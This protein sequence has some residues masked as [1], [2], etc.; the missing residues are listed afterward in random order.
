MRVIASRDERTSSGESREVVAEMIEGD[1]DSVLGTTEPRFSEM[2]ELA[3]DRT[4]M[5]LFKFSEL[6]DIDTTDAVGHG[7]ARVGL[8]TKARAFSDALFAFHS[9]CHTSHF[10]SSIWVSPYTRKRLTGQ[11]YSLP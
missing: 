6:A 10:H 11:K 5:A 3:L 1:N 9:A 4:D 8:C 7:S 2:E